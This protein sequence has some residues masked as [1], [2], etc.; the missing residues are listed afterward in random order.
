[1]K[2]LFLAAGIFALSA[3]VNAQE[4]KT[5]MK[6]SNGMG[7]TTI[8]IAGNVGHATTA[9]STSTGVTTKYDLVFGGDLQV[10]LPVATGLKLTASAGYENFGYKITY[11]STTLK[12]HISY[13]PL[14][15]GAKFPLSTNLYG[16]AQLGYSVSTVSGGK[17][18]FTYAPSIGYMFSKNFDAS[19]KYIGLSKNSSTLSAVVARLAYNF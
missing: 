7:K 2:K 10:D 13:I 14:L 5:K 11:G 9:T 16:H 1:M 19:V 3:T 18:A 15:A 6:S 17:G 8:S 12:D 4:T